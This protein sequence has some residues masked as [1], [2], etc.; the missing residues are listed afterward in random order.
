MT[1]LHAIGLMDPVERLRQQVELDVAAYGGSMPSHR[2]IAAVLH[3]LADY[4]TSMQALRFSNSIDPA[5][6]LGRFLHAYGD[7]FD[8]A[9]AGTT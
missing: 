7:A 1:E 9:A 8:R 6:N 5:L 4:E 3:G 2:Q